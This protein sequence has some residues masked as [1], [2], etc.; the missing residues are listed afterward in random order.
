MFELYFMA[1][2]PLGVDCLLCD[3][4][5]ASALCVLVDFVHPALVD[6]VLL[7]VVVGNNTVIGPAV[8]R[9]KYHKQ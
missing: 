9:K 2:G 3:E 8:R 5:M 6:S 1:C 7:V 4:A